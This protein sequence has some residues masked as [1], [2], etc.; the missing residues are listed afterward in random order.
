M[1]L[2]S[3]NRENYRLRF[4]LTLIHKWSPLIAAITQ[5]IIMI[6]IMCDWLVSRC[7]APELVEKQLS[8]IIG[9]LAEKARQVSKLHA[10]V[11][12]SPELNRQDF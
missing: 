7:V 3:R 10:F 12:G 9:R 6:I 11:E 1:T 4:T 2:S 5:L 8:L